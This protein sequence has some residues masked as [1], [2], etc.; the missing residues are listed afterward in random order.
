M[1]FLRFLRFCAI[2]FNNIIPLRRRQIFV[3]LVSDL[4]K[5]VEKIFEKAPKLKQ[6]LSFINANYSFVSQATKKLERDTLVVQGNV[7]NIISNKLNKVLAKNNEFQ[8][9]QKVALV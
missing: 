9:L 1:P 2:F 3:P 6:N 8:I 5:N 4:I 7:E